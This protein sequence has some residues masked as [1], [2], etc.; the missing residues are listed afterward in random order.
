[1]E[2]YHSLTM[3]FIESAFGSIVNTIGRL[4][5]ETGGVLMGN[6]NDYVIRKFIFDKKAKTTDC[7]YTFDTEYLNHEIHKVWEEEQLVCI[8]IIHSH[9]FGCEC[10]SNEDVRYFNNLFNHIHRPL[11]LTPIVQTMNDGIFKIIPY[12][13]FNKSCSAVKADMI[14]II[15]DN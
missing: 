11:L 9:P 10:L 12:I 8:G 14:K 5:A 2:G 6:E 4:P 7:T 3:T 13:L 1:M 15:S